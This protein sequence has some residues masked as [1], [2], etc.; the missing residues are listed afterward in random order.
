MPHCP[1]KIALASP[2]NLLSSHSH[3][4]HPNKLQ[5]ERA[6][7]IEEEKE[8]ARREQE[9]AQAALLAQ[10]EQAMDLVSGPLSVPCDVQHSHVNILFST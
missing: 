10:Q 2:P 9:R 5:D 6:K 8:R 4:L 7:I 1:P 3:S